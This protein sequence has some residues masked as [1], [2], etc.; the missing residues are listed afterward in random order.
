MH[1]DTYAD[2]ALIQFFYNYG[3]QKMD[4]K[5]CSGQENHSTPNIAPF[6]PLSLFLLSSLSRQGWPS[7]DEL[8]SKDEKD[9]TLKCWNEALVHLTLTHKSPRLSRNLFLFF[10]FMMKLLKGAQLKPAI[11]EFGTKL[12]IDF[13]AILAMN[14]TDIDLVELAFGN[15]CYIH[16]TMPVVLYLAYKYDSDVQGALLANANC[17][18]NATHRGAILGA[19]LGAAFGFSALPPTLVQGLTVKEDL[20]QDVSKFLSL[21]GLEEKS[22]NN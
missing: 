3:I 19:I 12:G 16:E 4:P 8:N 15:A 21:L 18:G 9:V 14:Q 17:G 2:S 13:E 22:T 11:Q 10:E 7:F 5:L 6:I 20:D 1:N